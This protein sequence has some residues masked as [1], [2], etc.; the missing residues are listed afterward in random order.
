[1]FDSMKATLAVETAEAIFE[2]LSCGIEP[3]PTLLADAEEYGINVHA[4]RSKV[5]ELY[6][7]GEEETDYQF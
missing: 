5:E 2:G 6:G 4:I 7:S 1:M 3:S